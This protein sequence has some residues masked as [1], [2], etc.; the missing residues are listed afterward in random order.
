MDY[1][2]WGFKE[3]DTTEH[4]YTQSQDSKKQGEV[5]LDINLKHAIQDP[6]Q[7]PPNFTQFVVYL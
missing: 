7:V 1:I 4:A 5:N 2:P 6:T 3:P